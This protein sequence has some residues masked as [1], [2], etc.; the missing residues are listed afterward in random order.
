MR[1]TLARL[2]SAAQIFSMTVLPIL[3]CQFIA[4]P[5]LHIATVYFLL[6]L[7]LQLAGV[8]AATQEL[9]KDQEETECDFISYSFVR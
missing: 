7:L 1:I 8:A 2:M 6:W 4:L 9:A 5:S 3:M